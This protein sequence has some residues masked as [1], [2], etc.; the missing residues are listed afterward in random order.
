LLLYI[1]LAEPDDE[2]MTDPVLR[3]DSENVPIRRAYTSIVKSNPRNT[4]TGWYADLSSLKPDVEHS[5]EV[6]LPKLSPGQF[7]GLYFDT[8][9]AEYTDQLARP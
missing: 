2:K 7:L 8:V 5:V 3:V 9:E 1:N 6:E 4:F